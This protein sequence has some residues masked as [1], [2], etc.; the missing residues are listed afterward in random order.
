MNPTISIITVSLNS[1]RTIQRTI[2]SVIAQKNVALGSD[3]E[4]IV[5]DG[6]SN[7]NTL[8]ILRKY[9]SINWFSE[10]D[11]GISDAFNKGMKKANGEYIL[12][13]NADDYLYDNQVIYDVKK[14]IENNGYPPW[15]VGKIAK[16]NN[17]CVTTEKNVLP[18]YGWTLFLRNRIPHPGVLIKKEVQ[19]EVGGFDTNYK[20]AMDYDLWVRLHREGYR[21][22]YFDRIISIFSLA[23]QSSQ[24]NRIQDKEIKRIKIFSRD[25]I[26]KKFVGT[27]YDYYNDKIR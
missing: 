8:N 13:L 20:Y 2:E 10:L 18:P 9:N 16:A 21:V 11:Y 6:K 17:Y 22:R 12:Y 25:N 3:Y 4:H 1:G 24:K 27:V 14:F 15:V 5:I 23:G 7:D 26:I 19:K